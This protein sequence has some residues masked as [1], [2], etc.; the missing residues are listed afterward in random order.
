M[1]ILLLSVSGEN[2]LTLYQVF[3]AIFS[4]D[5]LSLREF[6][7]ELPHFMHDV[8]LYEYN[9]LKNFKG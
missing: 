1:H 6:T 4:N 5:L 2:K 3:I 9:D 7:N 8:N